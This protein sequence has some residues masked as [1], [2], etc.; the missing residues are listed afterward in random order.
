MWAYSPP[1]ASRLPW[2]E[3]TSLLFRV[4]IDNVH[5]HMLVKLGTLAMHKNDTEYDTLPYT[6][7]ITL[8]FG[9]RFLR[10]ARVIVIRP[11]RASQRSQKIIINATV[12]PCGGG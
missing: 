9:Q 3:L 6:S 10:G 12:Q 11:P 5:V 2:I 4:A 1:A 7:Y 8:A